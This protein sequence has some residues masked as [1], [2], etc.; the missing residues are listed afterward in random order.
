M[1]AGVAQTAPGVDCGVCVCV[2][3]YMCMR[4]CGVCICV[5]VVVVCVCVYVCM[6]VCAYACMCACVYVCVRMGSGGGLSCLLPPSSMFM[7]TGVGGGHW[8]GLLVAVVCR[9]LGYV[10]TTVLPSRSFSTP[11]RCSPATTS[12]PAP[13]V[14]HSSPRSLPGPTS[15]MT[16]TLCP[17]AEALAPLPAPECGLPSPASACPLSCSPLPRWWT[18]RTPHGTRPCFLTFL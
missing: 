14:P 6:C 12:P 15:G 1:D 8:S 10:C 7:D 17:C 18:P 3:V 11:P 2:Y 9:G 13:L 5:C 16:Q 4:G